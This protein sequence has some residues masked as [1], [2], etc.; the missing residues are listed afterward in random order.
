MEKLVENIG[1]NK[2]IIRVSE[3]KQEKPRR[4][5]QKLKKISIMEEYDFYD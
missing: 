2:K 3:K 4:L 1:I 5:H